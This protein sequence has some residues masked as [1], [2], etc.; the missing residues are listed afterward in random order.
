MTQAN[1]QPP[2]AS[3]QP[4]STDWRALRDAERA[5]KRAQ[6]RANRESWGSSWIVG[7]VLILVG[8]ALLLQNSGITLFH[9]WWALF[10]LIP[11]LSAFAAAWRIFQNSGRWTRAARGALIGGLFLTIMMGAFLFNI[12]WKLLLP[13]L[14]IFAGAAML[15]NGTLPD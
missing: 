3:S 6:R 14:L 4:Q 2:S 11:A 7:A 10:I 13:A 5:E 12:E 1:N 8:V 9:N 15:M